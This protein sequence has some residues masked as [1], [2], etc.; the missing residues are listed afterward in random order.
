MNANENLNEPKEVKKETPVIKKRNKPKVKREKDEN[1]PSRPINAYVRYCSARRSQIQET[2]PN[3][4]TQEIMKLCAE[5]WSKAT[6]DEKQEYQAAAD[7]D[8]E[9]YKEEMRV[10]K[11]NQKE[12]IKPKKKE[13]MH[14]VVKMEVEP[15]QTIQ[16][17]GISSQPVFTNDFL[18][19]NKV[20]ESGLRQ[21]R[22]GTCEYE[23]NVATIQKHID[24][25]RGGIS[26]MKVITTQQRSNND[27]LT[28]H[29]DHL[30][31]QLSNEFR[32]IPL[33]GSNESATLDNIDTYLARLY[34]LI[35]DHP[36]EHSELASKVKH[37]IN[38]NINYAD[39]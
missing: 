28:R 25:V 20:A 35:R 15:V 18:E 36:D 29:L 17:N 30:R 22:R 39:P 13:K 12:Q 38:N 11:R 26:R 32:A 5:D 16:I 2:N 24:S 8:R 1:A 31:L 3:I 10:Y 19:Q 21:L 4:K 33:P 27:G 37:I 9:R 23:E 7:E 34:T 6:P 14:K